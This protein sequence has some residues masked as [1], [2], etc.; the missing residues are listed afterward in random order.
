MEKP[1][2]HQLAQAFAFLSILLFLSACYLSVTKARLYN[3]NTT[4]VIEATFEPGGRGHGLITAIAPNGEIFKGEY[5]TLSGKTSTT[6]IASVSTTYGWARAHGFS[7]HQPGKQSGSAMLVG[8]KGRVIE[9]VYNVN[10][11]S[12]HGN[13]V[14]RDNK[15]NI[16]R[17]QF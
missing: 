2:K 5:S 17:V 15:G 10:A 16:F 7:L 11:H 12:G 1:P 8:D 3:L 9:I 4:E 6:A 14:A 13:G